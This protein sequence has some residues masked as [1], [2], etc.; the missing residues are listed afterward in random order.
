MSPTG[1]TF[2]AESPTTPL[3]PT[4]PPN[5]IGEEHREVRPRS[6]ILDPQQTEEGA[7]DG[8]ILVPGTLD[9][10]HVTALIDPALKKNLMS[11]AKARDLGLEII[12]VG[13]ACGEMHIL[14][15]ENGRFG[16]G[17]IMGSV[18]L[19]WWPTVTNYPPGFG[20]RFWVCHQMDHDILLG[21]PFLNR[22]KY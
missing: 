17:L 12:P 19:T 4:A 6:H 22:G 20:Q 9:R 8:Y 21:E 14:S 7:V 13:S 16:V 18:E 10:R 3:S 11:A 5:A 15:E 1:S 2:G